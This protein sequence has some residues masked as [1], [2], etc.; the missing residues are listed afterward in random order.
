MRSRTASGFTLI[1]I[2][3]AM[4]ILFAAVATSMLAFQNSLNN[5]ER[6]ARSIE[7]LTPLQDIVATIQSQLQSPP[8]LASRGHQAATSGEGMLLNVNYQW[9]ASP[10][11]RAE[12]Y[13]EVN[14]TNTRNRQFVLYEVEL[15]LTLGTLRRE[16]VYLELVWQD[17]TIR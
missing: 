1:E 4:T 2:L 17:Q 9:Q 3:V 12:P 11:R 10:Y 15:E 5:T 16:F 13:S 8:D 6:A 14:Q 7:I